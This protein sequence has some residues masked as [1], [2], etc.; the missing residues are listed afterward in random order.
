MSRRIHCLPIGDKDV[1]AAQE[2]CWCHPTE[3]EP[4]LW[5]HNAADCREARERI[6]GQKC[7][8]GWVNVAEC[9]ALDA[10]DQQGTDAKRMLRDEILAVMWR[11]SRESDVTIMETIEAAHKAAERI[12][13]IALDAK[14]GEH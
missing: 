12:A 4:L 5:V 13:Q 7:S 9:P 1:H 3:I 10:G 8:D 14:S 6:T 11:Y 2:T